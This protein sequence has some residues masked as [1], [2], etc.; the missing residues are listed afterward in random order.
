MSKKSIGIIGGMGPLATAD[1]F[2]KIIDATDAGCDQDHARVLIDCNTNIP[3]RTAAILA[4]GKSPVAELCASAR[5]LER[6][7]ADVLIM[8]CNTAHY[9]Y[10]D[11]CRSVSCPV[12]SITAETAKRLTREGYGHALVL[13]TDGTVRA[14]VYQK[15]LDDAGIH[16]VYPDADTQACLMDVIYRGIKAGITDL[17]DGA[18]T[19]DIAQTVD[20]LRVC[21]Q[22]VNACIAS[23]ESVFGDSL[24]IL[25]ACTE[26]PPAVRYYKL[27]GRFVDPTETLAVAALRFAGYPVKA[28][29]GHSLSNS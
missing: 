24:A 9:F 25:P 23:F 2:S 14:G 12:L 27:R 10:D 28:S 21:V 7:G 18:K 16:A 1:L 29:A 4:G 8:P 3:D 6:S 22:T 13:A 19:P 5:L 20:R 17:S 11:V 15:A 26:L